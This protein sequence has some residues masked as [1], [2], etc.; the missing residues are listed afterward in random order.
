M[1]SPYELLAGL[2][3]LREKKRQNEQAG[4]TNL[5]A[6][7]ALVIRMGN[8]T[9]VVQQSDVAEILTQGKFTQVTGVAP[10][11][12]GLGFFQ[13][14]L[15][16]II[17]GHYLFNDGGRSP[18]DLLSAIRILVVQG[19]K[20]WF[21]LKVSE[22]VGIRHVWSDAVDVATT[23]YGAWSHYVE[24]WIKVEDQTLPVLNLKQLAQVMESSGV[25]VID[26]ARSG[27]S[28]IN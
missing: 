13:G 3:L 11:M 4:D 23:E 10:W 20:E 15:L 8:K 22:L 2:A 7:S 17:D 1:N 18:S 9:C 25:P 21:G 16:N 27:L 12:A 14:K 26:E 6:W 5:S 19:E 24:Q 28:T